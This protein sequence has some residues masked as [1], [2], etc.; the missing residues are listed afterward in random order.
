MLSAHF[1]VRSLADCLS[2]QDGEPERRRTHP[3]RGAKPNQ[4]VTQR[5]LNA[6]GFFILQ[7]FAYSARKWPISSCLSL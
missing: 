6:R 4:V 1:Q 7:S 3:E 5:S 2:H